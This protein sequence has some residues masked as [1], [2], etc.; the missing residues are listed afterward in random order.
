MPEF[1][2][3]DGTVF[4]SRKEYRKYEMLTQ[5]T[6]KERTGATLEKRPGTISG[7]PFDIA[8]LRDCEVVLADWSDQVQIDDCHSCRI[9]VGACGESVFVRNCADC[10]LYVAAKQLRLRECER[11]V[12]SLYSQTEPV[13]EMSSAIAFSAFAGGYAGQADHMRA[14]HLDPGIN[15]WWGVFDFSD[16]AKTGANFEIH[17]D[18]PLEPWFPFNIEGDDDA[19]ASTA[20]LQV[21]A[22]TAPGSAPLPSTLDDHAPHRATPPEAGAKSQATTA[23]TGGFQSFDI[24]AVSQTDAQ[25]AVDAATTATTPPPPPGPPPDAPDAAAATPTPP[26]PPTSESTRAAVVPGDDPPVG[27]TWEPVRLGIRYTPMILAIQYKETPDADAVMQKDI[28]LG[29]IG[30]DDTSE[31]VLAKIVADHAA[32]FDFRRKISKRQVL[33]LL[34]MLLDYHRGAAAPTS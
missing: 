14:A 2:A 32:F 12:I 17:A 21:V 3:T 20:T 33:R 7:Q 24:R 29:E 9:F 31:T 28:V 1:V 34:G 19:A 16:E 10:T 5:Y 22:Q 4:T 8:D 11:C 26:A 6:F 15:F 13:I 25:R 27:G 30:E 18:Q 23:G